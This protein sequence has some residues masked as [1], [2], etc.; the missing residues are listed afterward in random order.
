M[1]SSRAQI[2]SPARMLF[3]SHRVAGVLRSIVLII[4]LALVVGACGADVPTVRPAGSGGRAS[5]SGS[6]IAASSGP[7]DPNLT[8]CKAADLR[9]AIASWGG[10]GSSRFASVTVTSKSGLTCTLRGT[11]GVRLLDGKG[12]ILLDSAKIQGIGG[13]KVASGDLVVVLAAGDELA[14]DVQWTNWCKAQPARPV[15]VS[16]VLTDRGGVLK[17]AKAKANVDAP[18]CAAKTKASQVRLTHAWLGPGL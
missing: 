15:T 4:G 7:A 12:R 1:A 6:A 17:A 2:R 8:P 13:P 16:L 18:S 9:A 11:P 14:L 5:P 3:G 10:S